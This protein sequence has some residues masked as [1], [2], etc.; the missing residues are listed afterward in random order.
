VR[1]A[2]DI[3]TDKLK[4][5]TK[6]WVVCCQDLDTGEQHVFKNLTEDQEQRTKF[7]ALYNRSV[8]VVGHNILGFDLPV[9]TSLL[10]RICD[11]SIDKVIDTLIISRMYDYG[12]EGGHSIE[13]YGEEFG[14]SKKIFSAFDAFSEEMVVYCKQDTSICSKIYSKF[15]E[16]IED[17]TQQRAI[18]L[19][20]DF[21]WHI[22]NALERNGFAFARGKAEK[23][24]SKVETNLRELDEA[25]S[26]A[27]PPRLRLVKEVTPRITKYGTLHLGDFRW[28][29]P[30]SD[31]SDFNGGSFCRCIWSDFN[32]N[33]HKQIV[34]VL[35]QAK[36]KPIDKT[37]THIELERKIKILERRSKKFPNSVDTEL[38]QCYT[39]LN[40]LKT[41]G[42]KVNE[43]N[44]S[45]LP[46]RAPAPAK[47][48]A[49]RILYEARRRSLVEWLSLVESDDRIRGRFQGIGAW[50]MRMAHQKPNTAN[51]PTEKNL[52][53]SA[54]LLGG[55]MRSLWI[56]PKNRLLLG[57]DAEG[58][59]L[60]IFAHYINDPEFTDALV[61]GKKEEKTDPHSLNQ[62]ILGDTCKSRA[63]AKRY[64]YALLLGA[65][66]GKLREILDCSEDDAKRAFDN[67]LSRYQ[68]YKLLKETVIPEDARRG[69]FIGLDGQRIT[70]PGVSESQKQHLSMSGYLQSGEAKA[71]KLASLK[72]ISKLPEYDGLLVNFVHD[73]WQV[74]LANDVGKAIELGRFMSQCLKEAGEDLG[75]RCPLAGSYWNDDAKD[76]TIGC[77]WRVTH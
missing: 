1:I 26:T 9:L 14:T 46:V 77:N 73:E 34:E 75:L 22:V 67:L 49:R 37:K 32:P 50:T 12:H 76:Y 71:M 62:R 69:Y 33:S 31:L 25:I 21:Q 59:Q 60:R 63:A 28:L 5:P 2:L 74:E 56:A 43:N 8:L 45:T 61:R 68:G 41:Y 47:T 11:W 52:D 51:I 29:P 7:L 18:R 57:V 64:I 54:K 40:E 10:G 35:N 17:E 65:G 27:F 19:E 55:E 70:I 4:N 30:G 20:H 42:W 3:E 38:Q 58:I 44:L 72:F 36:W 48:L 24:L 53:G 15:R 39:D 13:C 66:M 6:I 23:L 16:R